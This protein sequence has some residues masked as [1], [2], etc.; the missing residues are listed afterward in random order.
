M[1]IMADKPLSSNNVPDWF[2]KAVRV[3][4]DVEQGLCN[5]ETELRYGLRLQDL[6]PRLRDEMQYVSDSLEVVKIS[7]SVMDMTASRVL[8]DLA[9]A[10]RSKRRLA[11]DGC[12]W[13]VHR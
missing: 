3:M 8:S 9:K 6:D 7:L 4:Q 12:E 11:S 13:G 10:E 2:L 1:N 5:L